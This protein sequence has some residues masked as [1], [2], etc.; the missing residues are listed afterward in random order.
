MT[1]DTRSRPS[2]RRSQRK[3]HTHATCSFSFS[4]YLLQRPSPRV[5]HEVVQFAD[6]LRVHAIVLALPF[7]VTLVI[8]FALSLNILRHPLSILPRK[9]V[10]TRPALRHEQTSHGE[11]R[12]PTLSTCTR[13]ATTPQ[14]FKQVAHIQGT[15]HQGPPAVKGTGAFF[16]FS[17]ASLCTDKYGYH[18]TSGHHPTPC[19]S[20][21][22]QRHGGF[23]N[24]FSCGIPPTSC[25]SGHTNA[26]VFWFHVYHRGDSSV[27]QTAHR[28]P[29]RPRTTKIPERSTQTKLVFLFFWVPRATRPAANTFSVQSLVG[30]M[31]CLCLS[32]TFFLPLAQHPSHRRAPTGQPVLES[33]LAAAPPSS[34]S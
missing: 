1:L 17:R 26:P 27:D 28:Q 33:L 8:S 7:V 6:M 14:D 34:S 16:L 9:T 31:Y 3:H 5:T 19:R 12:R 21:P 4:S 15:H 25:V 2:R 22:H 23:P 32:W 29:F 11:G 30:F 24:T 20:V 10:C 13:G 18:S